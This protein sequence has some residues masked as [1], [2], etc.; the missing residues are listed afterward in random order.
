MLGLRRQPGSNITRVSEVSIQE[1]ILAK[2][3]DISKKKV[4]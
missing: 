1:N 2:K 4:F 3:S